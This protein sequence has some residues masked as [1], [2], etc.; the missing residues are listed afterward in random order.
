MSPRTVSWP[1]GQSSPDSE[2]GSVLSRPQQAAPECTGVAALGVGS[3][4]TCRHSLLSL[5]S[6]GGTARRRGWHGAAERL[7]AGPIRVLAST[8]MSFLMWD[9]LLSRCRPRPRRVQAGFIVCIRRCWFIQFLLRIRYESKFCLCT[10][11]NLLHICTFKY[12]AASTNCKVAPRRLE[13][14]E[15]VMR[16]ELA[17]C[18]H[19][20]DFNPCLLKEVRLWSL[21]L[22][23]RFVR[24]EPGLRAVLA[25]Q[26]PWTCLL[27]WC[28]GHC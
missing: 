17:V 7:H 14:W 5:I 28:P 22:R 6:G 3:S 19:T 18:H 15:C 27:G 26:I 4:R 24:C 21:L 2:E 9:K 23:A 16:S 20:P 1:A 13:L 12:T 10:I 25:T 11:K 8:C